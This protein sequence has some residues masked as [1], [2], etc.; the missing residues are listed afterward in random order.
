MLVFLLSLLLFALSSSLRIICVLRF[1]IVLVEFL[2]YTLWKIVIIS[3]LLI[4]HFWLL[5]FLFNL[6]YSI[7]LHLS[8]NYCGYAEFVVWSYC[9]LNSRLM[10]RALS[11]SRSFFSCSVCCALSYSNS[12]S[13]PCKI[14][15]FSW[16]SDSQLPSLSIE[17][18]PIIESLL[19]TV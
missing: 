16:A 5:W 18:E 3:L 19:N 10:I 1:F 15:C 14:S 8:L 7:V 9:C 4:F 2:I 6:L 12:R 11:I 17:I 13:K